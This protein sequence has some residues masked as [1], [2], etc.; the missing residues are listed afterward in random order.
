MTY[1]P[2]RKWN[3]NGNFNL[4]HSET[5]GDHNGINYDAKNVSWFVRFNNKI[6]LPG[7]L[8][9]Q[10]RVFYRGPNETA[11]RKSKGMFSA[12]LAFS[13]DLFED[14]ASVAFNV[15]D[16][17]NTR[18]RQSITE[19]ETFNSDSEF[20]W[21]KRSFNLSFTYRFNQKKKRQNGRNSNDDDLDFEGS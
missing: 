18:K 21:R 14:K 15:S 16:V 3:F 8:D 5:K 10:T 9:W 13:K 11:I 17:L 6:T 7:E 1:R 20:Q 12:N 19:T 4:Y 2:T